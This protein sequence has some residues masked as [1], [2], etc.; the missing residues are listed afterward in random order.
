[1]KTLFKKRKKKPSALAKNAKKI[2]KVQQEQSS[3]RKKQPLLVKLFYL[4]IYFGLSVVVI[5][6]F[7]LWLY[8]MQLSHEYKLDDGALGGSLWE[9]PSR[10]YARPLEL[11]VGKPVSLAK[12][13]TELD[14]MDYKPKPAVPAPGTY[15][16]TGDQ[17]LIYK[18]AFG[19][20]DGKEPAQ[21][22]RVTLKD[23]KITDMMDMQTLEPVPITRLEPLL[24]GSIYP[25]HGQDRVL[26]NLDD[27]PS[28]LL[29]TVVATEDRRFYQH[30]GIDPKGLARALFQGIKQGR[31]SQ[32]ASTITQQFVKNHYL[33]NERKISRKVKEALIALILEKNYSKQQILEGYLNEI[34]L[35]QDGGRAIHGF[36]LAAAH[37]FGKPLNE[38]GVHQ[39]AT[40]VALVREPSRS[41]PFKHPE[42]A[43]KRRALILDVMAKQ[44][45]ISADDATLA[46][47][48]PLDVLSAAARVKKDR[49]YSFLQLVLNRIKAE[50]NA[51]SLAAGL[52]IFTTLDP[53][54]QDEAERSV[55]GALPVLEK[56][57]GLKKNF[58][59]AA[60]VIV[61]TATAEVVA[62][63]GDRDPN[64]HGFNRAFQARRQPG[65]LLKPVVYMAALE[66]PQR[67]NLATP[68]DDSPLVYKS[69]GKTWKPKNY[70]KRNKG[71]VPLIDALVYSYNIPTARVALDIGIDDV[72]GRLQDLGARADLPQY[73][74]I[75]LGS[76]T[77]S[78]MEVAQIYESLANG[79]YRMPLRVIS[80]VTDAHDNPVTRYPME[81]VKVISD[82][83]Y[84]L[85]TKAMQEIVKRGTAKRLS[86]KISPQLH[87]AGKTGTTDDYRDSWFAGFSGNYLNVVWVGND[88]NKKTGLSGNNGAMRVWMDI[89]K[90]LPLQ[91]LDI[92]QPANIFEFPVDMTNGLLLGSTC[93]GQH[94]SA[95]L[96]FIGGSEPV[97][98][99]DCYVA[100]VYEAVAPI[101]LQSMDG[102]SDAGLPAQNPGTGGFTSDDERIAR[103][104]QEA[105]G[106]F[107]DK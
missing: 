12:L 79:G 11:Y 91:P 90:D 39:I 85:I 14:Y 47:S 53:M 71:T 72:V 16:I 82:E 101:E 105:L 26:I 92:A 44:N 20:W 42:F 32:G 5:V 10:V 89:M 22:L 55:A 51:D 15:H 64:R 48:L 75:V 77:M 33:N 106:G 17:A 62:I 7:G 104:A 102:F 18:N 74:S 69:G 83:P 58:L 68:I 66:Y 19:Y 8:A 21:L 63:V 31:I 52:N 13:K 78:P 43:K 45:L 50:Y 23:G 60:S 65:S 73:P 36:G 98:Y 38:L 94:R 1:M 95:E 2:R 35:G 70:S 37:Y 67:Y 81:S 40:L 88:D 30:P 86:D 27:T 6:C 76:V 34:F 4:F 96:P 61:N 56:R 41:N 28:V 80:S 3:D 99:S 46:K 84:Y 87:I 25:K 49:Y 107:G 57:H 103:D 93:K 9:L 29:D 97:N 54:I 59:Q 100:P 24:I